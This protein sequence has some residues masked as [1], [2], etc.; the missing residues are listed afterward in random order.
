MRKII[1]IFSVLLLAMTSCID[2][3]LQELPVYN[4]AEITAFNL[5]YRFVTKNANGV[6]MMAVVTLSNANLQINK[7][8][9]TITLTATIPAPTTSFT[10]A[11]R[12]KVSLE[13][14]IAYGKLSPAAKIEPLEG[15]PVLGTPGNFTAE[16][17]YKVT[18]ADGKTSKIW[19]IKINPLPAISQYEGLYKESGT[20][21]RGTGAPEALDAD[22][23]LSTVNATTLLA[24]AGKSIFDNPA[25]L[26]QIKI[27]TDN[28]VTIISEPTASVTIIPQAGVPSTYNPTTKTFDLHY[29]YT[30]SALRKFDTKLVLK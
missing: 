1:F 17:K 13:K 21:V 24:Q 10:P 29:E 16:R 11:E 5:E 18:A 9:A 7:E 8:A 25:I 26:Y 28:T 15:A 30:T 12:K 20:L 3:G 4:E 6:D 19:T 22:V 27:N 14:I 23:Y 2:S